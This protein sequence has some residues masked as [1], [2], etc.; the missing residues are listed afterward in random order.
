MKRRTGFAAMAVVAL[1]AAAMLWPDQTIPLKAPETI[2]LAAARQD[3]RPAGEFRQGTRVVDAPKQ[4]Q[5][6][7]TLVIMKHHV[8]EADYAIC[9][10]DRA[11]PPVPST[12]R[13]NFA[14]T[15]INH[16]DATAY[17]AWLSARTGQS[18]RLP[19]DAEW[20]RAAAERGSEDGFS[21]EANGDDPSRR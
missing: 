9:V 11:C 10:A 20:L 3:Y 19:T 5:D 15:G 13:T 7:A 17:A 16:A 4:P 14:Q 6:A 2:Q 12:G 18:W 1:G 21:D 8:S